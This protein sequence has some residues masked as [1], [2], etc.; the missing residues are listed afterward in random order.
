MDV[1]LFSPAK[2]NL[3]LAVTGRRTDGFHD[4]VSVVA[5]L[6][7]GDELVAEVGGGRREAGGSRFSLSCDH[8]DVPTDGRNLVLEAAEK[9]ILPRPSVVI[10]R[11]V[12]G[13]G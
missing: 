1:S 8:P 12:T 4:L 11:G 10:P 5:P 2:I 3:F 13:V 7:F 6:D 9:K